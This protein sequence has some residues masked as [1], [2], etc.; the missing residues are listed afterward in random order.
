MKQTDCTVLDIVVYDKIYLDAMI[1]YIHSSFRD[2]VDTNACYKQSQ[3]S[4]AIQW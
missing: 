2:N 1:A 4:T 3:S